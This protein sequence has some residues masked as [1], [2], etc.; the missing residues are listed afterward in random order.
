MAPNPPGP[1][2][3]AGKQR[4]MDVQCISRSWEV[5][6]AR[7]VVPGWRRSADARIV[8]LVLL[9]FVAVLFVP[10]LA[11]AVSVPGMAIFGLDGVTTGSGVTVS[12]GSIG[13]RTGDVYLDAGTKVV[14]NV[15]TERDFSDG[16]NVSLG[17]IIANNDATFGDWTE[18]DGDADVG[19]LAWLSE[20]VTIN[21]V[22]TAGTIDWDPLHPPTP[23]T[24]GGGAPESYTAP[25]DL[26]ALSGLTPGGADH[27]YFVP[28]VLT[29]DPGSHGYVT[30]VHD[31]KL[32]LRSD[33]VLGGDY[34]LLGFSGGENLDISVD[35]SAGPVRIY[36]DDGFFGPNTKVSVLNGN[37]WDV[38]WES[39]WSW[40]LD[41]E[42]DWIG[43]ILV[44]E[45]SIYV[46]PSSHIVGALTAQSVFVDE[47][48]TVVII[49]EP[50]TV[51]GVLVG[52]TGVGSYIRRRR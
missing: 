27:E 43:D 22:L 1:R 14:G 32:N 16:G 7:D 4:D 34:A 12:G 29:L 37:P 28:H 13:S 52:L 42:T 46:A 21:G 11:A 45:G 44:T 25:L 10:Q 23:P 26:P 50:L 36:A 3:L 5:P 9:S 19:G 35:L 20:G 8:M 40:F 38:S 31:S 47:N 24:V 51:L 33:P 6:S 41:Q 30:L 49:P 17:R 2:P 48:S 15:F 39:Q 18:V